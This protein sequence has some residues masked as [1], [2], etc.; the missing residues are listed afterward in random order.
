M[1][2]IIHNAPSERDGSDSLCF[3]LFRKIE[4]HRK[5][6]FYVRIILA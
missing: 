2:A 4:N 1:V 6:R 5:T 3:V